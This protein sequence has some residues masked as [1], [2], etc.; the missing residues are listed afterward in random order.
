M[1]ESQYQRFSD[2]FFQTSQL[3]TEAGWYIKLRDDE[4]KGPFQSRK[5]ASAVLLNLFGITPDMSEDYL[6]TTQKI[7][8]RFSKDSRNSSK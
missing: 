5:E 7:G 4:I 8:T 1:T 6:I 3:Y 2:R